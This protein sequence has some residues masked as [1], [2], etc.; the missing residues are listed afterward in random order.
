M[1]SYIWCL[2]C[3]YWW[4]RLYACPSISGSV[5]KYTK[6]VWVCMYEKRLCLYRIIIRCAVHPTLV[7]TQRSL[8]CN[9]SIALGYAIRSYSVAVCIFCRRSCTV[10]I[11]DRHTTHKENTRCVRMT[12][13]RKRMVL[14]NYWRWVYTTPHLH[15][16]HGKINRFDWYNLAIIIS[17]FL[18]ILIS[19]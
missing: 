7:H 6:C 12:Y 17:E 11:K 5:Y 16:K 19:M 13:D 10:C 15:W 8:S 2:S 4:E 14:Y 9:S 3:T 1:M 18:R